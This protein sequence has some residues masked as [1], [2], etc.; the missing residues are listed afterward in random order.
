MGTALIL[1]SRSDIAVELTRRFDDDNWQVLDWHRDS[2]EVPKAQ[3]NICVSA[4]GVLSPIGKFFELDQ[5]DWQQNVDSN[6]MLPLRL[7]REAW[8]YRAPDASVCFFSGAGVSR[9][10]DTYS[11]YSA[12]KIMLMKM[13]ELL[14]DEN[15]DAKFFIL[16]PGMVRTKI[17]QQTLDAGDR[18]MNIERVRQ[19]MEARDQYHGTGTSHDRIYDCL[20]WC[21]RQKKSVVGG[22]NFYVPSDQWGDHLA[23]HLEA[24]RD[25][26][27][28]RRFGGG[29]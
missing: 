11:G 27:K 18:A 3:W 5:H 24:N 17:Q 1:G 19:F 12:S 26:F 8:P 10:A 13:T 25:V 15:E 2:K 22:R 7:L 4:I 20:R 23:S 9:R 6:L 21:A 16:G 29:F 28:L 14:D